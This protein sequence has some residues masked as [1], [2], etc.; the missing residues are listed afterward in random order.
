M[1]KLKKIQNKIK[2]EFEINIFTKKTEEI[3]EEYKINSTKYNSPENKKLKGE[4]LLLRNRVNDIS[5]TISFEVN[6][7]IS[8]NE[9]IITREK[10]SKHSEELI[11]IQKFLKKNRGQTKKIDQLLI[12]KT[13]SKYKKYLESLSERYSK[14]IEYRN[15]VSILENDM[16]FICKKNNTRTLS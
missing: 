15:E 12:T 2:N 5:T 11:E 7:L 1:E 13:D 6:D 4:L 8:T 14:I 10:D 3:E 9:S 16:D